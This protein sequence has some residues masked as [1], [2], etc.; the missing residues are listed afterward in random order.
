MTEADRVHSTP[1]LN[2]SA[3]SRRAAL[4]GLAVLP[5]VAP[6]AA[7]T[8]PDPIYSVIERHRGLSAQFSAAADVSAK[9]QEGPEFEA[10]DEITATRNQALIDHAATLI[11]SE[12]TTMAGIIAGDLRRHLGGMADAH[13]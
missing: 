3:I 6:G 11:R 7:A 12:P 4:T 8:E 10:A 5:V 9:L 2:T 13:R 1:P